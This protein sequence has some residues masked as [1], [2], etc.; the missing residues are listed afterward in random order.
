ML[1][2]VKCYLLMVLTCISLTTKDV[3]HLDIG[4]LAIHMYSFVKHLVKYFAHFSFYWLVLFT[5]YKGSS[6][7]GYKSLSD[8]HAVNVY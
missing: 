5:I 8:A 4:F 2:D 1:L 7:S 6:Y 3:E